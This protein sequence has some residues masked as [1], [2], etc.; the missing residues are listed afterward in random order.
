MRK[1]DWRRKVVRTG[2][3]I[4]ALS[5][6]TAALV[7][8]LPAAAGRVTAP[9]DPVDLNAP[10]KSGTQCAPC[11][12]TI[13]ESRKPGII[14]SHGSHLLVSCDG[15]HWEPPHRGG[16]S[17]GPTMESCFNCHGVAHGA[18]PVARGDCAACHPSTFVLRPVTH[19]EDW[20][21]KPHADR[22]KAGENA[23]LLCHDPQGFCDKC[24]ETEAPEAEPTQ[25]AYQ[26]IMRVAPERPALLVYPDGQSSMGQCAKC[27]PD[28]DDFLPGRVIFAHGQHLDKAFRCEVCHKRFAHDA[29]R[30]YRPDM[31]T[32]YACHG[33]AH[34][35]KTAVATED[36]LACHPP[37]FELKPAD[38]T[39]EFAAKDHKV[40]FQQQPEM[41]AMCHQPA[42]CTN[43]HLGNPAR[44]GGP[45]RPR[46]IPAAHKAKT[47]RSDH[48]RD[49]LKEQST[50]A[51]CH[52]S[53]TCV[54]CHKTPV[55]HPADFSVSHAL[56]TGLDAKDCN[57]CH[58][59]RSKC[60]QCHHEA[61]RGAELI[62]ENCV[63]CHPEMRTKP[64][65]KIKIKG[66]AEHAVHF[67]VPETKGKPYRCEECHVGFTST[68]AS[69]MVSLRLG[70]DL[71]LCYDCHGALDYRRIL[72]AKY[73][74]TELCLRCHTEFAP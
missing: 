21:G 17:L 46:I 40:G 65:T 49:Y 14:F 18:K 12:A 42:F 4:A 57:V 7:Y 61:L 64:A 41:C 5:A 70:H 52:D 9:L 39:A 28:I 31:P 20:K 44:P 2:L 33:L 13:G 26:P 3:L 66:I 74:G 34:A 15:C 24:H 67:I 60:Q 35:T 43:C 38:H 8:G 36:C 48:G 72:I 30:T 53:S 19:V 50:C 37:E 63:R 56:A 1:H 22:A 62:E 16:G 55:P 58:V 69:R 47:F 45:E 54:K 6:S 29:E 25:V 51:A 23:C 59:D 32:C 71:R 68:A 11:H 73:P 27:H 10:V